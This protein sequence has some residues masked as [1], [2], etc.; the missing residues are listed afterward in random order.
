MKAYT[1]EDL[2][3]GFALVKDHEPKQRPSVISTQG[4]TVC[5]SDPGEGEC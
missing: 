3:A 5:R 2:V 4:R 1:Q